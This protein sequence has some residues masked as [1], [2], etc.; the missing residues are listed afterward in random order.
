MYKILHVLFVV[1]K[2]FLI[3]SIIWYNFQLIDLRSFQ[4]NKL[5]KL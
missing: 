2:G 1:K 3:Y 5:I 4:I